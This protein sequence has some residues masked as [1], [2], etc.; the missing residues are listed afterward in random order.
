[1]TIEFI[2]QACFLLTD[3]NGTRI[4]IDPYEPGAFGNALGYG[5]IT[6]E[7]D[8]VLVTHDHADHSFV[9]G[10]PGSPEVC[11]DTCEVRGIQFKAV[12]AFH[13]EFGGKK[14]GTTLMFT[15][16]LDGIRLCHVGDLGH[17][18]TDEQVAAIG[19]VDIL[20]VPVGGTFT[21]DAD[22]AWQVAGQLDPR[23][24]IPMHYKTAKVKLPL[25]TLDAFISAKPDVLRPLA[26]TFEVSADDLPQ[27]RRIVVLEPAN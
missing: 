5:R 18:L 8:I 7:A 19:Q 2:G 10:V 13:D 14:R 3:S 26:S 6:D 16:A 12:Q 20:M 23:I 15:F 22:Q 9:R 25:A 27:G 1:M 4:I 17:G 21:I 24:V 11:R